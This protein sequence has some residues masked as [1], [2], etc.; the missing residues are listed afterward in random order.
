MSYR[1]ILISAPAE[2]SIQSEYAAPVYHCVREGPGLGFEAQSSCKQRPLRPGF[3]M[4]EEEFEFAPAAE[5]PID[6]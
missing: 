6:V 1:Q 2:I 5:N 3:T 4:A